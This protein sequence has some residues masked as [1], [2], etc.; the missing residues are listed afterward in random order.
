M[1]LYSVRIL[2]SQPLRLGLTI[3]GIALCIVLMFFL[4]SIYRGVEDGSVE[5]IRK[6]R[7][8]L[9]VLQRN[10]WNIL[11]GSSFLSTGHGILIQSIPG[12]ESVS[13]A[14]LLLSGIKKDDS[15]AT[16]FLVGYDPQEKL[17]GPPF[18]IQG[19]SII[20]DNEI[21]LDYSFARKLNFNVGDK[22][23]IQDDTLIVAGL[24]SG[25]NALVIQYAFVTL[26][27]ARSL[28]GFPSLVTCFLIQIRKGE[29]IE[30]ISAEIKEELVGVEVYKH[31]DFLKN[32]IREMEMGFLPFLLVIAVMGI[33]VLTV[34]L[35]LLLSINILEHRKDY[36]ILKILGSPRRFL[37][38]IVV[39]QAFLI[40]SAGII[41]ALILYFPIVTIIEVILPEVNTI[42]TFSQIIFVVIIVWIVSLISSFFSAQKLRHIYPLEVFS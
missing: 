28:I 29:D 36:A 38:R 20:S 26:K 15:D 4:L 16:V 13:P 32:N 10:A 5:Y 14:L 7:A 41:A 34:I 3:S 8:D 33:I 19:R 25:T 2:R 12:V 18:I 11:R 31:E 30:K 21:I 42:S 9:W 22:V 1:D 17:G 40:S 27:R 39:E 35:S 37:P 24:S 6:N 23:F